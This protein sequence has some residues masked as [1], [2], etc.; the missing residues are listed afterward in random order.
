MLFNS[1]LYLLFFPAVC[2]IY[3]TLPLKYRWLFLL[4][5]SYFFYLNWEP[6][7]AILIL[8][9]TLVTYYGAKLIVNENFSRFRKNILLI[10]IFLNLSVLFLFK[11]YNF[12]TDSIYAI[13]DYIGM[14]I[15]FPEFKLLLPVGI[16]FYTF[17]AIGYLVDVYN[18]KIKQSEKLGRYMLFVAFFPQLVAGP[19]ERA[20]NLLPQIDKQIRFSYKKAI[21]GTK[22]IIWGFFMKVV[23]ADRLAIYVDAVYNNYEMHS[24]Y[25]LILA[26]VF[27][28]FQIYC[29]FGGYSNIAIGCAKVLGIDLMVNFKRPYFSKS[30]Q[31]FWYRWHISLSTWFKD[32][33][34]IPLGGNRYGNRN[35]NLMIT[36]LI[37]G[38]WH[39]ANW[40]FVIWG[41]LNGIYL[42]LNNYTRKLLVFKYFKNIM[43]VIATFI[44]ID[45]SWI[46]FRSESFAQAIIIIQKIFEFEGQLYLGSNAFFIY[47]LFG[48][49][50]LFCKDIK[51]EFKINIDFINNDNT[52]FLIYCFLIIIIL[53]IGVFDGGQ[54]I[55]FQ[56]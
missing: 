28:A 23:I 34:Y 9:S 18:E 13:L 53:I 39:G 2:V 19:I 14:R 25:T 8:F 33:V 24:S 50:V 26:S 22:L 7:Y 48:L 51:D 17:Q 35:L 20:S 30:V 12:F 52:K 4:I 41:G 27:F 21:E 1:Y 3:Y 40:T 45:I 29:D 11:Y 6:I 31:E 15:N 5:S 42:I 37:S 55:Y 44:L 56:F 43:L 49:F 32:Y 46:F 36:F 10:T 47:M 54:F 16:S 38:L